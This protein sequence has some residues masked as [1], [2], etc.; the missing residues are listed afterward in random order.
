MDNINVKQPTMKYKSALHKYFNQH[1]SLSKLFNEMDAIDIEIDPDH[2]KKE[3]FKSLGF[4]D[5]KIN[6]LMN[7]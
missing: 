7:L 1:K 6:E 2:N 5:K 3:Y 4:S